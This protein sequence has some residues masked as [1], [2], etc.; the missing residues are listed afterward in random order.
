MSLILVSLLGIIF[1]LVYWSI[2]QKALVIPTATSLPAPDRELQSHDPV[3]VIE[4]EDAMIPSTEDYHGQFRLYN[5]G[6]SDVERV[7]I[8]ENYYL[9]LSSAPLRLDQVGPLNVKAYTVIATLRARDKKPF[10]IDYTHSYPFLVDARK[11]GQGG[12]WVAEIR[13]TYRRSFDGVAFTIRKVMWILGPRL[14]VDDTKRNLPNP[15]PGFPHVTSL[16]E[17][18]NAL[19]GLEQKRAQVPVPTGQTP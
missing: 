17:I 3:L 16:L 9:L 13:L 18:A 8:Y 15:P 4:P 10:S 2:L 7:E 11:N 14:L 1:A 12:G 6:T 19:G 5:A